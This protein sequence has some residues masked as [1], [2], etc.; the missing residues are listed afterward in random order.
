M[1]TKIKAK[2]EQLR[3]DINII[4][5]A[6]NLAYQLIVRYTEAGNFSRANLTSDTIDSLTEELIA[7]KRERDQLMMLNA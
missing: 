4:D 7:L 5:G 6:L 2:L 1:D 3:E